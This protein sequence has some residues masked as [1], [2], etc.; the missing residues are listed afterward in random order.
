MVRGTFDLT[1]ARRLVP[2]LAV[3]ALPFLVLWGLFELQVSFGILRYFD[4]IARYVLVITVAAVIF[5]ALKFRVKYSSRSL[6]SL[7]LNSRSASIAAASSIIALCFLVLLISWSNGGTQ[8]VSATG[9]VLP[10]SD[11]IGYFEGAERLLYDG[12][13]TQWTERRPLNAAFFAARLLFAG[14]N[15]YGALAMQAGLAAA[16]LFL[17]TSAVFQTH[18]KVTALIFFAVCFSFVSSCLHRTL[19]EPLGISLGLLA[20]TLQW[21]GLANKSLMQY[22]SGIFVLSLAL[23]AR[24]GA[25]FML[26][27]SVLFAT[28]FFFSNWRGRCIAFIASIAAIGGAWLLNNGIIQLYGTSGG[29]LLSNFSYVIYGLSQGG[30]SWSQALTDFPQ[31]NGAEESQIAKFLYERTIESVLAKP[32]LLFLGLAKSFLQSIVIFPAHVFRLLVDGSDGGSPWSLTH[33][34]ISIAVAL[35]VLVLGALKIAQSQ[36]RNLDRFHIFLIVQ[37]LGFIVSL[38]FFYLDGGIRLTA[39]TFPITAV[40]IALALSILTP[41]PPIKAAI[42]VTQKIAIAAFA[43]ASFVVIASLSVSKLNYLIRPTSPLVAE[44]C[45]PGE[46]EIQMRIGRGSANINI[47]DNFHQPSFA[48]NIRKADF[49]IPESNENKQ[50]WRTIPTPSTILMGFDLKSHSLRQVIGPPGFAGGR[51]RLVS[52]C[53][54]PLHDQIFSHR[55]TSLQK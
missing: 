4:P 12:Y 24:A 55:V 7:S 30:A 35:P 17:A 14:E 19:S 46:E 49:S 13:L 20:F 50:E 32:S 41:F 23:L 29:A 47:L 6:P 15:F 40:T 48:P 26:P 21:S 16:A 3:A 36:W 54:T 2:A 27:A 42:F 18:G 43:I 44:Q 31:L 51:S 38:P 37:L 5:D 25:M 33:A 45:G 11:A 8:D 22:A 53:A 39:A 52:L 10:Y 28:F 9:G 34:I 1:S